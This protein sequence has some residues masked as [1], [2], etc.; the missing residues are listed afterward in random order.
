MR[1]LSR[2]ADG[3]GDGSPQFKLRSRLPVAFSL[4]SLAWPHVLQNRK[5][6][7][8][9]RSVYR[10]RRGAVSVNHRFFFKI[11]SNF[12][13]FEKIHKNRKPLVNRFLGP[14]NRYLRPVNR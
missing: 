7:A 13:K 6:P 5:K 2:P 9:N 1:D 3:D 8:V 11:H 14:V 10:H 4:R 12:K